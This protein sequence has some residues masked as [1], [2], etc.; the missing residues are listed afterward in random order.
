MIANVQ[1]LR[2]FAATLV[3][4]YHLQPMINSAFGT[5]FHSAFGAIGVDVFFVISG[6]IMFY[7]GYAPPKSIPFFMVSRF[8]RIV[9]LY[10]LATFSIVAV[11]LLGYNPNGLHHLTATNVLES[12]FFVP[13]VFPD[14][15]HDLVL[16]LGWTL[17][18]E[19]F[20]YSLFAIS[21]F[22]RSRLMSFFFVASTL[23]F[24]SILGAFVEGWSYLQMFFLAPITIE[25]L[26]GAGL[27]LL[28]DKISPNS[29]V[30]LL[31]TAIVCIFVAT[32]LLIWFFNAG[33]VDTGKFGARFLIFGIPSLFFVLGML[34]LEKAGISIREGI[35]IKWGDISYSLY[36][37]HP[38]TLQA[39]VKLMDG[40]MPQ[41]SLGVA[42]T[43]VFALA[44][45][46]IAAWSIYEIIETRIV[47][48]G[49]RIAKRTTTG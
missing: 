48:F 33:L 45:S 10:W 8:F 44:T 22:A 23:C 40:V 16:S 14:G 5:N 41:N 25:F 17:M 42:T 27:G 37:F 39:S 18:Y 43:I 49:K 3:V 28:Y 19:L 20:F 26:F 34:L 6:F 1:I 9:P 12:I 2:G 32:A 15:R 31:S 24:T 29:K 46:F 36:L 11:F 30:A 13:S 38:L 21:F 35:P 7:R 4:W 47:T